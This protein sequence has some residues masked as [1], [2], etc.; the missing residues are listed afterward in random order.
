MLFIGTATELSA[1]DMKRANE[2]IRAETTHEFL[3]KIE[4][5]TRGAKIQQICESLNMKF[6]PVC[7]INELKSVNM[8]GSR[9]IELEGRCL[10]IQSSQFLSKK[11]LN[12]LPEGR[13]RKHVENLIL[14]QAY[15]RQKI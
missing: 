14:I 13:C 2:I 10:K 7:L 15:R 5:E 8:K 12:H 4:F 9:G 11:W 1:M 6:A 3:E